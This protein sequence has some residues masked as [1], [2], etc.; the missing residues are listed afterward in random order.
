ML[1]SDKNIT[2]RKKMKKIL[3][4]VILINGLSLYAKDDLSLKTYEN[5]RF[6]FLIDYPSKIFVN[7]EFPANGDGI[8]LSNQDKSVTLTPSGSHAIIVSDIKEI[9]KKYINWIEE[10]KN[11]QLTYKVQKKNWFI[12]SGFKENKKTIFYEKRMLVNETL[13][14][15]ELTYPTAKKK[16]YNPI[17]KILN[18]SL[19]KI[20]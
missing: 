15:Y 10:E 5:S 3:L 11:T 9:Y 20:K 16:R 8:F 13:I 14:G 12:L 18:K 19:K 4:L 2:P 1:Q 6:E 17:I 7:K